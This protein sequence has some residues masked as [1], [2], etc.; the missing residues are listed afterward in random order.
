MGKKR[1]TKLVQNQLA[2]NGA[3]NWYWSMCSSTVGFLPGVVAAVKF[4]LE[5]G[6]LVVSP[7]DDEY[8]SDSLFR[9]DD[10]VWC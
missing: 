7:N 1:I 5:S 6:D 8:G 9:T 2:K 10:V 4:S 3:R